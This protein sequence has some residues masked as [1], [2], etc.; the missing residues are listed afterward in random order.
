MKKFDIAPF[1]LP[2]CAEDGVVRFEE[3]R[4]ILAIDVSFKKEIPKDVEVYY[5]RKTWP[6]VTIE[7]Y[8]DLENPFTFG[9][10]PIDDWFNVQWHRAEVVILRKDR[11]RAYITF[12]NLSTEFPEVRDKNYDVKFRRTLGIKINCSE[13]TQLGN[14][15]IYTTSATTK[16]KL[17]ITL[18]AGKKTK[19]N[20][21]R[22]S[23][24]N[25]QI[26]KISP[27]KN[28]I[29][30]KESLEVELIKGKKEHIFCLLVEHMQPAHRYSGDDGHVTFVMDNETFTI[31]LS[32]LH[33][34]GPIWYAEEGVYITLDKNNIPFSEYYDRVKKLS[35]ISQMVKGK[36]EQSYIRAYCGQPRPHRVAYS[37]GCKHR[38]QRFWIEYNGDIVLHKWNVEVITGRDTL[39][40][41]NK[42]NARF[43][44]NLQKSW[45]I[46]SNFPD[47]PPALV[48]NIHF[49]KENLFL[50]QKVFAVPLEHSILE[51]LDGDK[52]SGDDTVVLL[53][54]FRFSNLSD[55]IAVAD[56]SINYSGDSR[57]SFVP[58]DN[59]L[60]PRSSNFEELVIEG[61]KIMSKFDG[62]DVLR[63]ICYTSMKASNVDPYT[64]T[65]SEELPPNKNCELIL[66]IPYIALETE[67][68][69]Q[70]LER[71]DFDK[72]YDEVRKFW[73]YEN[74]KGAQLFTPEPHLNALHSS[75]LSHVQITDFV[76][77]D[78]SKLINTSV[79]TSTYGNCSN[80]SCMIIHELDQRGLF[81]EARRRL[82]IWIKY[83]G[84]APQPGNFTDYNGMYFGAGG[85]EAGAYNQH[86]GWIL[87]CLCEHFFLSGDKEWFLKITPSVIAGADWVF[88]QRKN[89]M[90]K[91]ALYYSRGWEYGFLPAGSLEDVTD[92]YYWLTTN[93]LT[94][95]GVDAVA[96]ALETINHP[97]AKRIRREA[98]AYKRDLI[99]GFE[100]MR[101]Y[102]PLVPLRDGRWIPHYPSRLYC[103]GRD[104]GWIREVLEGAI[105]LIISGLYE[106]NGK[107]AQWIL[108]DYQDTRYLLPPYGYR[109]ENFEE[110][111]YS[112]GG[113]S[114]QP[115]LLAG[116]L[117]YILRDEPELYIWSFFNSWCACYREEINAMIEHP[118]P[119]LGY[120]NAAH[121]KT[122][123]EA[124]A[125]NWLRYMIV[126]ATNVKHKLLHFGRCIPREWFKGNNIIELKNVATYFGK[127]SIQYKSN[128]KNKNISAIINLSL[129][130]RPEKILVR[131]R[132]PEK[133][134]MQEVI[135][136]NKK[137]YK[138][139]IHKEDVDITEYYN[140]SEITIETKY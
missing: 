53:A 126:F 127:V 20:T 89:T 51:D 21:V 49:M 27:L 33:Q 116:P 78:G 35:T 95:R 119:V 58:E 91:K 73:Q 139:D 75:H 103:R 121:F 5:L 42:G 71:L 10:I 54:K 47:N 16:S 93:V 17:I 99:R 74:E 92:F 115:N 130:E 6:E 11:N 114:M 46:V 15:R 111:W 56:I 60:L 124:N 94:W 96:R 136:N 132:H 100:T 25:A 61:N 113:F 38:R 3:P 31:S 72:S 43:F 90:S 110:N 69:F 67:E 108:D 86:H 88:R 117:P 55:S 64:I 39:R 128:L 125:V 26:Q 87:W 140:K 118:A 107:Q 66:K 19:T 30:K 14:I 81:E 23:T 32:L 138:F 102:S 2:S 7:N 76:M 79:G 45:R 18:N 57:R 98:D 37:V 85:F 84:T 1:A 77:P 59:Y 105:Y 34:Q 28:V 106:P 82:E 122:S 22:F 48:Y 109:I 129:R 134:I 62:M 63:C 50:E 104:I 41:K 120:S 101:K 135:V 12:K 112:R 9:W 65:F 24:Y 36:P 13:Q 4:D 123:D 80:E 68:E 83:Q 131:F 40:F 8:R 133:S 52:I 70:L 29:L 97:E 44:F 137:H